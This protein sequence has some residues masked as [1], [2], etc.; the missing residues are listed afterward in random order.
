MTDV[1]S[2]FSLVSDIRDFGVGCEKGSTS[3]VSV[4]GGARGREFPGSLQGHAFFFP[5]W[6]R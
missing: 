2:L 3:K 6:S 4:G 5:A 1:M